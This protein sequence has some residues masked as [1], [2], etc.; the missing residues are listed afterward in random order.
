M[1]V[2]I[3]LTLVH[4]RAKFFKR[5]SLRYGPKGIDKIQRIH[6]NLL[7]LII[8]D[9]KVRS[10]GVTTSILEQTSLG[11]RLLMNVKRVVDRMY[12]T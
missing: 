12:L 9:V 10:K 2:Y 3:M 5:K 8:I 4:W 6:S 1:R 11:A 7:L